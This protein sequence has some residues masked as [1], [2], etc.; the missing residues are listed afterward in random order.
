MTNKIIFLTGLLGVIL[1][2]GTTVVGGV[3]LN[4]Y[5]HINQYISESYASGTE[6]ASALRMYGFIPSGILLMIFSFLY[7]RIVA[8]SKAVR[9]AFLGIGVFYGLG[10]VV[11]S[12][13]PCDFGCDMSKPSI[14]QIVHNMMG[15]LTYVI[16]PICVIGIGVKTRKWE[17]YSRLSIIS[18]G[19]GFLSLLFVAILFMNPEGDFK[20]LFQR[21]IEGSILL[22]I[23]YASFRALK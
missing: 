10:T 9:L 4:G 17:G 11:T 12:I 2:V 15:F 3:Q 22:W 16:V 5:S 21:V 8:K 7:P 18:L 13:F 1:F 6:H 20:G 23:L 19:I 14:S